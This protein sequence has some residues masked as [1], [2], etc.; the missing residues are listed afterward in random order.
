MYGI[1]N[2]VHYLPVIWKDR[3]WDHGYLEDI[4]YAKYT[5]W[6]KRFSQPDLYS[7][8]VGMEKDVQAMRILLTIL[9]RRR[10]NWYTN[11]WYNK[12]AYKE[13]FVFSPIED[14]DYS[15]LTTEGLTS[16]ESNKSSDLLVLMDNIEE[17]DWKIFCRILEKYH[18]RMWD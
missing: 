18:A 7:A 10:T 16:E 17:R 1:R 12:Y 13:K 9:E 11:Q 2:V 14:S 15:E 6:Y 4:L 3:D 5:K 8:Y